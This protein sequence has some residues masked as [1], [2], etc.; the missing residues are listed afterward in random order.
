VPVFV[1]ARTAWA[2]GIGEIPTP[3]ELPQRW[4]LILVP[5]CHVS[6]AEIFS[7]RQLTRNSIPIKMATFFGGDSRNDCQELVRSLYP[8]VDKALKALDNFGEARLTGTGA[9]VFISFAT[10]A[11]AEAARA[12]LTSE[13]TSIIARGINES[14]LPLELV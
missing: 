3:L 6:T 8:Q 4:Y 7:H 5:D 10:A 1:G 11:E 2:E 12:Q 14:P 9:C 13:C